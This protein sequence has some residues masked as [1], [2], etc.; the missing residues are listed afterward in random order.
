MAITTRPT[1]P[2]RILLAR[3]VA[4]HIILTSLIIVYPPE[5]GDAELVEPPKNATPVAVEST[6]RQAP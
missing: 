1:K 4:L 2:V 5:Y 3:G 6:N